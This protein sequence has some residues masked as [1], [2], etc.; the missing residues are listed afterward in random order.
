M[1]IAELGFYFLVGV[2][3]VWPMLTYIGDAIKWLY[4]KV[5]R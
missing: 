4:W 1:G 3:V 5:R 2:L